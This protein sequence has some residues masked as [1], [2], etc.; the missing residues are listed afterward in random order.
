M[1]ELENVS[2]YYGDFQALHN[3]SFSVKRGEIIGL[4]GPN[5][6]GKTT[7]MRIL[8][9]FLS[10]DGGKVS[11]SG[12]DPL[13][14]P[15]ETKK[16]IGYLPENPL[17][18][19]ELTVQEFL[20]FVA[21]MK[22]I[23]D[24]EPEIAAVINKTGLWARKDQL[25]SSL[26][27]GFKQ[28]VGLAAALLGDPPILILDEPTSGLDPNQVLEIR[29]LIREMGEE[30][31]I[32]LST[33]ILPE[34]EEICKRVILIDG[35][36]IK[37]VDTVEGLKNMSLGRPVC[38]AKVKDQDKAVSI[39]QNSTYIENFETSEGEIEVFLKDLELRSEVV[40]ELAPSGLYEFYTPQVSLEAVFYHLT[41]KEEVEK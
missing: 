32:I 23:R 26:S 35:G 33:H 4:L 30:K 11:I 5:G 36:Q 24:R 12:M 19:D 9:G 13:K 14:S 16:L 38:I 20:A 10:Y 27:R 18:Y 22:G 3:I 7:A 8:T 29:K 41:L 37:T 1:I 2:K 21:R 28:R 17:L 39:L 31:T 25:I 40:R 6:A 34:V 15:L